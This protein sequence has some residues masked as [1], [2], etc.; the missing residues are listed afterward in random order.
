MIP[1]AFAHQQATTDWIMTRPSSLITSDP[2][3]GKTRSV[4]D[5]FVK[6]R[7]PGEKLLVF[8]PLSILKSAWGGD[9]DQFQPQ[10]TYAIAHGANKMKAVLSAADVILTN[11]D[12]AKWFA[13]NREHINNVGWLCIDEF[14]AF[15][16]H[17]TQRT[18]HL[19]QLVDTLLLKGLRYRIAMSGTPTPN[20]I[21]ELWQPMRLVDGG[22][23]LGLKYWTFRSQMCMPTYNYGGY[24]TWMDKPEAIE[25]VASMLLDVNIRYQLEDCVDIPARSYHTVYTTLNP[26][27]MAMYKTMVKEAVIELDAGELT[28]AV[29]AGVKT[30]KLLQICTGAVY[31]DQGKASIL[32]NGRYKLVLELVKVRSCSIVCCNW[33]HE[34]RNLAAMAHKEQL[35]HAVINGDTAAYRRAEIVGRFQEGAYQ[36]LLVHPQAAGHGLTLTRAKTTIWCSPTYNSEHYIQA[37]QRFY[38][39]GQTEKTEV[40]HIAA[41][42]TWEGQVYERSLNPKLARLGSLLELL[43]EK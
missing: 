40:I 12:A 16:T 39:I 27:L 30:R 38:R 35:T 32:D 37:N 19:Q 8:G 4:L 2:G 18:K 7:A 15:K 24:T 11:H 28:S 36:M 25:I 5:A 41:K 21:T 26:K 31:N 13:H 43:K 23:R 10:L 33:K 6:A 29:N 14:T 42:N 34:I 9:I 1:T 3:T 17:T 22:Q 20:T